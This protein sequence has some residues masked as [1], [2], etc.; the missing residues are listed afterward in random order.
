MLIWIIGHRRERSPR[1]PFPDGATPMILRN[2]AIVIAAGAALS[3]AACSQVGMEGGVR[4]LRSGES[5]VEDAQGNALPRQTKEALDRAAERNESRRSGWVD[6]N[7][8]EG[9][10]LSKD[11]LS[12]RRV[13]RGR[14]SRPFGDYEVVY[15]DAV[16]GEIDGSTVAFGDRSDG[17]DGFANVGC[18]DLNFSVEGSGSRLRFT[19]I[20]STRMACPPKTERIESAFAAALGRVARFKARGGKVDLYDARGGRLMTLEKKRLM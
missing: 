2:I 14:S 3:A 5:L 15:F 17:G 20:A 11:E 18:N 16:G 4:S 6:A 8:D 1:L 12:G 19:R 13:E 10:I 9:A 7:A